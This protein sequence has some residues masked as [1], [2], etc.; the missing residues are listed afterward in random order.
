MDGK[1]V[2]FGTEVH[3]LAWSPDGTKAAI[4]DAGGNLVVVNADGSGKVEVA[5]NP[6]K[7]KWTHPTWQVVAADTT[8]QILAKD[9]IF[10]AA[11]HGGV[12]TLMG[13]VATAHDGVPKAISLGG[14]SGRGSVPPPTTGNLWPNTSGATASIVYEHDQGTAQ[15]V[16]IRDDNLR[17]QGG[18]LFSGSEPAL[19]VVGGTGNATKE[20]V[21]VRVVGGH[22][23]IV[24]E[25]PYGAT[26][27]VSTK[28]TDL[29]PS[30]AV[31]AT[32]PTWSPDGKSVAFSTPTG[33][34]VVNA[35]GSGKIA[36]VTATPGIPVYR[37]GS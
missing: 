17:Q 1:A 14:Y 13:V 27:G 9:N 22:K 5:K 7:D 21:L 33:V 26:G 10:F 37:P 19:I 3:D 32:A 18:K 30:L 31:D 8:N 12:K 24:R 15:D 28:S 34:E 11:D 16:Y 4:I 29:T 25:D 23:H 6:G 36:Q 20:V 2:D 35:D